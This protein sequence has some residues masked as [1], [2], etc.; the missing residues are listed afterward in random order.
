MFCIV[1]RQFS[2]MLLLSFLLV[3]VV[4]SQQV[5]KTNSLQLTAQQQILR[6]IYQ[7]LIEINTTDSIGD[8][9][10]AAGALQISLRQLWSYRRS[11]LFSI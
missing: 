7:E 9:T 2:G 5:V 1:T 3:S 11:C 6:E 8:T 4:V 10:K